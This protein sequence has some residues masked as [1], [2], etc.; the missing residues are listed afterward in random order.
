MR[1]TASN[2]S[3]TEE[4]SAQKL[5]NITIL[6]PLEDMQRIDC[7]GEG[8]EGHS[9]EAPAEAF[10]ASAALCKGEEVMEQAP[11]DR[12]EV[13]S[14]SSEESDPSEGTPWHHPLR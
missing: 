5:S 9:V 12:E 1:K 3:P 11:P 6:D 14:K 8:K 7:F 2:L 4:A 10:H 13:G